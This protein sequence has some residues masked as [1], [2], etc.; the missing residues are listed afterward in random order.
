M[1]EIE[2]RIG[3]VLNDPAQM[4]RLSRLAR[5]LM[6]GGDPPPE[7]EREPPAREPEAVSPDPALLAKLGRLLSE[8][9]GAERSRGELLH[10]LEPWL[11]PR[12][13]EKLAR[14]LR[15]ARLGRLAQRAFGEGERHV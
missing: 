6:G 12:R 15:L 1:G 5:T 8:D 11:A 3:Q 9:A 13:R 4:E 2:E 10:A 14:A 7:A